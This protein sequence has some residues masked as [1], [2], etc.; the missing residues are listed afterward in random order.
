MNTEVAKTVQGLRR[1]YVLG[2]QLGRGASS[3][4]YRGVALDG[5]RA[6][7]IKLLASN[8]T[9][10]NAEPRL[11]K[12]MRI[13]VALQHPNI[14]AVR[15]II[16]RPR[17]GIVI[18]LIEGP[19]LDAWLKSDGVLAVAD[20]CKLF[21]HLCD[22][23]DFAHTQG[24]IHRDV[25]PG[26]I[27]M[28]SVDDLDPVL[29]DFGLARLQVGDP[30]L[31]AVGKAVGTVDYMSPEQLSGQRDVTGAVDVYALGCTFYEAIVG[32]VPFM[33]TKMEIL[34]QHLQAEAKPPSYFRDSIPFE[35][36][37]LVLSM[38]AKDPGA[39][40]SLA[41]VREQ[42]AD[43]HKATTIEFDRKSL[44]KKLNLDARVAAYREASETGPTV[45]IAPSPQSVD[46]PTRPLKPLPPP[47]PDA[48]KRREDDASF[49]EFPT[50][51][52]LRVPEE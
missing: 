13:L 1:A 34:R 21:E 47:I 14:L 4:V 16:H 12:E 43:L 18:D 20:A 5:E 38:L 35:V 50:R 51:P 2:E 45:P 10:D 31:T 44:A 11:Q 33:G 24:V 25:K 48:A 7:A 23:L 22:A 29:C 27:L 6:H 36:D 39:R 42:L 46:V 3:E 15:D 17:V 37:Q 40:P 19:S 49:D 52:I 32:R 8:A 26:N 41:D 9:Q 28:R 30:E